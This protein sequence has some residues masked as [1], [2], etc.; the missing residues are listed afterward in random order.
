MGFWLLVFF[1]T[2]IV[3]MYLLIKVG[4]YIGAWPTIGLV[5]LTAVIGVA[6]LRVQGLS[7]LTRGM[8]R[9]EGGEL[10]AREMA[11]GILLAVAGALLI[12]PG[13]FTDAAGFALL[14]P[15]IRG[16]MARRMLARVVMVGPG[17]PGGPY[18]P[19]GT[20]GPYRGDD[21]RGV[22]IEGEFEPRDDGGPDGDR[23]SRDRL[24]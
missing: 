6:L 15:P 12:T 4:G 20:G 16:A 8:G 9:L 10:P 13:F 21:G 22:V 17:G 7:T 1:L 18:G 11:E 23:E 5:M 14:V 24:P 2:P 19:G 3:E